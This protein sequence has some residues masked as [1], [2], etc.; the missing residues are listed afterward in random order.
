MLNYSQLREWVADALELRAAGGFGNRVAK[1]LLMG[2]IIGNVVAVVL[3]TVQAVEQGYGVALRRFEVISVG[4]FTMEYLLRLWCCP[5]SPGKRSN[6]G[7]WRCRL[8]F[9]VSP[10]GVI[11]LL[12]ILPFYLPV[13]VGLDLRFIRVVRLLRLPK[14]LK[15]AAYAKS[16]QMFGRV[17]R[18]SWPSLLASS[19]IT[20]VCLVL[21]SGL[22]Y[23]VE[24]GVA[25]VDDK[26][27][28]VEAFGTMPLTMWWVI[29]KISFLDSCGYDPA[30]P[31]GKA[32]GIVLCFLG[33]GGVFIWPITIF[34]NTFEELMRERRDRIHRCPHCAQPVG[35]AVCP[36]CDSPLDIR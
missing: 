25:H 1:L 5:P 3:E 10:L 24:Q 7:T 11:D 20:M 2:L 4:I 12:A 19:Y 28:A 9:V 8:R 16:L 27:R 35:E 36:K 6:P 31:L 21:G 33:I 13:F 17:I 29:D 32:L 26:G 22:L 34:T 15:L 18:E 30:T 23:F 14:V